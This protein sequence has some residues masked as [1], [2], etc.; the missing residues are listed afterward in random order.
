LHCTSLVFHAANY[1]RLTLT[2]DICVLLNNNVN[3]NNCLDDASCFTL[4]AVTHRTHSRMLMALDTKI[5]FYYAHLWENIRNQIYWS[6]NIHSFMYFSIPEIHQGWYK[7]CQVQEKL[8]RENQNTHFMFSN[9]SENYTVYER[10]CKKH[11]WARQATDDNQCTHFACWM[12]MATY[13]HSEYCKVILTSFPSKQ[14]FCEHTS[15]SCLYLH[16]LFCFSL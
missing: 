5:C 7:T 6:I 4:S 16:S 3:L 13:T 11:D 8:C 15:L 9:F 12:P 10:M 14:W 2:E 1:F